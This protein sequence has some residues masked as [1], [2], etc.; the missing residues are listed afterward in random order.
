MTA[1]PTSMILFIG[2][3]KFC[4]QPTGMQVRTLL[5][6][7]HVSHPTT[8]AVVGR[9]IADQSVVSV[10]SEKSYIEMLL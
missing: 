3:S 7:N 9:Y 4:P 8:I 5:E 2:L 6:I 10:F 1:L